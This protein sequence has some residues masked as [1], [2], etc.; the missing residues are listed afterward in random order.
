MR[1]NAVSFT[2][3]LC[4]NGETLDLIL[5][6]IRAIKREAAEVK[7]IMSETAGLYTMKR[8]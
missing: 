4:I 8:R 7:K 6:S 3:T 2:G 1:S 5:A